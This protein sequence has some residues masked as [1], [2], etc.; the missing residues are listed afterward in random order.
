M[1]FFVANDGTIIKNMPSP[2]YQGAANTN[3]IYLIAPFA[4]TLTAAVAFQ[5]PNGVTV[6]AEP[7]TYQSELVGII[8]QQTGQAYSGWTYSIPSN[9]TAYY[10]TV[11]AQFYFYAEG[12][13]VITATSATSFQV[14]KGVPADLPSEPSEDVYEIILSNIASLQKQLN[15]GAFAARAIYAWNS[16]YTYGANEITF[17]PIGQFGAFVKSIQ[18]NNTQVPY[19]NGNINSAY[20]EQVVSFDNI[21]DAYFDQIQ[22]LASQASQS[23][24]IAQEAANNLQAMR[25][26]IVKFVTE[27]PAVGDPEYLYAVVT[28]EDSNLFTLYGYENGAWINLGGENMVS[29]Y[30][31]IFEYTL[32]AT[33]WVSDQQT[34]SVPNLTSKSNVIVTVADESAATYILCGI[35]NQIQAGTITFTAE[36][37]PQN[38]I[39]VYVE[40]SID[41]EVPS[42]SG[43]Y[44]TTQTNALLA[45]KQNIND[46]T[47]TTTDKTIVGAINENATA[48]AGLRQ[49]VINTAHFKGF[50]ETA[51]DVQ[52][53]PADLNDYVY[54]IETGTIWVYGAN[55]WADSGKAYP[56]TSTPLSS[57][58]PLQDGTASAGSS[59]EAARGDHVHPT[60]TSR[61]AASD[62]S[63]EIT[64]RQNADTA[65]GERIDNIVNGTTTVGNAAQAQQANTA[66]QAQQDAQ[67][68]VISTYYASQSALANEVSARENDV[69]ELTQNINDIVDGTTPVASAESAN[70]P[71]AV[72][73]TPQSLTSSQQTQARINIG[74][75]ASGNY[76]LQT[77]TY[78]D[79]TV[80]NATN[81][82]NAVNANIAQKAVQD[83]AGNQIDTTYATKTALASETSARQSAD[84]TL[85]NSI[86]D[87]VDGTTPVAKATNAD[88]A[89]KATQDGSGNNIVATYSTKNELTEGLAG[90]QPSGNYALQDGTYP[91]MTVGEATSAQSATKATQDANGNVIT[92]TYG[93]TIEFT[94]DSTTYILTAVLKSKSGQILSTQTVDLPLETMVVN[95]TYDDSTQSIVL[96]LQNGTTVSFSVS[97]LVDGLATSEQL[98]DETSARETADTNLENT[99]DDII[100]GTTVVSKATTAETADKVANALTLIINGSS[101]SFDGSSAESVSISTGWG[102]DPEAVHFTAQTLNASQQAQARENINAASFYNGTYAVT[103]SQWSNNDATVSDSNILSTSVIQLYPADISSAM[104][105]NSNIRITAQNAGSVTLTCDS[106]PSATLNFTMLIFN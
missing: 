94:I 83:N 71:N 85:Q 70:D 54:C 101:V 46:D 84:T 28:D 52:Q 60:D 19:V 47:L 4:D 62:L 102:T 6:A 24:D 5:L 96:T 8:N 34:I 25:N 35:T 38:N 44:T 76:A 90:K 65:L 56:T 106:I 105:V 64:A 49:D 12:S 75:Q 79:M 77:G 14:A 39:V 27:L 9:I 18:T 72:H 82:Q 21:A 86:D 73:F 104:F 36:T 29:D 100:D 95:A 13:G 97:A 10:G 23:A 41:N 55:G 88:S 74:A 93:A 66:T 78:S 43:Y 103:T 32:P 42:L 11:T 22:D 53:I 51:A 33:S 31:Q 20:W 57:S 17:Y 68:N 80:G 61:A 91:D 45:L 2:V 48:I 15:N 26:R 3:T 67:G 81:A 92:N 98:N 99:I 37:I 1:I 50:A 59:N 89:T 87:I 63:A 40:V 69:A 16:E 58:T 7:M 30:T